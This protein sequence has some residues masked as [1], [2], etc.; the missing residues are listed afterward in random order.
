[1][2][3]VHGEFKPTKGWRDMD[4]TTRETDALWK[5]VA[6]MPLFSAMT[7]E[8][9]APIVGSTREVRVRRGE[10]I[11]QTWAKPDGFYYVVA[12]MVKL[13]LLSQDGSE[14]VVDI[15]RPGMSFGEA[16]M[17]V[18]KP[19][20]VYTQAL[21]DT[22]VLHIGRE[23]VLDAVDKYSGVAR[24]MLAGLS[25][26]LHHL[27]ADLETSCLQPAGQ[28]VIGYLLREAELAQHGEPPLRVVLPASNA[29][30]ASWLNVT[31]ETLSRVL[32]C[33]SDEGLIGVQGRTILVHDVDRLRACGPTGSTR[34]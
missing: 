7:T 34:V 12:G 19:C 21:E 14:K 3:H 26:R 10:I 23:A 16:L 28:R 9:L 6:H 11:C 30:V 24:H 29:T 8:E 22:T 27:M 18:N 31:P 4:D 15:V 2:Y 25:Q 1:M 5:L 13:A 32:H 20:P 17:F 33:L